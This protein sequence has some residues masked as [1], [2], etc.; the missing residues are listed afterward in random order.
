MNCAV[1]PDVPV[2][3]YCR[4]CGKAL[5]ES[6]KRDVRG[7][8]Y[9]EDCLAARLHGTLPEAAPVTAAPVAPA[10]VVSAGPSPGLAGVL[11][12]I[13]PFGVGQVYIGQY[14]KGLAYMLIFAFLVWGASSSRN[15]DWLFGLSIA[16]FYVFQIIDA[17]RSAH[18]IQLN[19]N[20]PD[21]LG[22][23][24]VFGGQKLD[25]AR[26][27]AGA[28][29]L[30]I[31]GVMLLLYT[32]GG[33]YW[34]HNLW[35]AG[36]VAIGVWLLA[37]RLSV[38]KCDCPRCRCEGITW[39]VFLIALGVLWLLSNTTYYDLDRTWPLLLIVIGVCVIAERSAPMTG[40][41]GPQPPTATPPDQPS[42]QVPE[43]QA[44]NR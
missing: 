37:R 2:S 10:V 21:P 35:P 1:H 23:N 11:S 27:P 25:T 3:A 4:T 20:V 29:V 44:V 26:I 43:N 39:P 5:C 9:C 41:K 8:I 16:F 19:Q 13:F 22:I 17:V 38:R 31:I 42:G 36:L 7:V 34:M 30:I 32:L 14:A 12:A 6:C 15:L 40:H 33:F 24:R 18:A 28:V